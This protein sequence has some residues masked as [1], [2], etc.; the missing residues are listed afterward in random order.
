MQ[1]GL[2]MG[3][4]STQRQD[5]VQAQQSKPASVQQQGASTK[6]VQAG[7]KITDWASI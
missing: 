2:Q 4:S 6:P 5:G 1:D 7:V 3:M